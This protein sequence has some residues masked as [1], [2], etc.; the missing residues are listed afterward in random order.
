MLMDFT[1]IDGSTL[2]AEDTQGLAMLGKL[3]SQ[4]V[5]DLHLV[6]A[7][8]QNIAAVMKHI[9]DKIFADNSWQLD[10]VESVAKGHELFAR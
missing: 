4:G 10:I 6:I 9:C 5:K 3:D 7:I 2:T 8:E 1:G